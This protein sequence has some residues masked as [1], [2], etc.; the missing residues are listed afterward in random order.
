M[1]RWLLFL[2][3]SSILGLYLFLLSWSGFTFA[4]FLGSDEK[5]QVEKI[6]AVQAA[7][8]ETIEL[9]LKGSGFRRDTR[10]SL[11]M[12][13]SNRDAIVGS[14]PLKGIIHDFHRDGDILFVASDGGGL[15]VLDISDSL[16]PQ[17]IRKILTN[18]PVLD[19]EQD[20]SRLYLSCGNRGLVIFELRKNHQLKQIANIHGSS[21]FVKSKIHDGFIYVAAGHGGLLIYDLKEGFGSDPIVQIPQEKISRDLHFY[22]HYLYLQQFAGALIFDVANPAVPVLIGT[23]SRESNTKDIA[24]RGNLLFTTDS[25]GFVNRYLLNESGRPQLLDNRQFSST[26]LRTINVFEDNIY[27]ADGWNGLI[28]A[29]IYK[30]PQQLD[31]GYLEIDEFGSLAVKDDLLYVASVSD[32]LSIVK[33]N[34]IL[35]RQLVMNISS[36]GKAKDLLVDGDWLFVASQE[37]GLLAKNLRTGVELIPSVASRVVQSF[38]KSGHSL[39]LAKGEFGLGIMDISNPERSEEIVNFSEIKAFNLDVENNFLV[40][41]GGKELGLL[42]ISNRKKPQLLDRLQLNAADV[43]IS[44]GTVYAAAVRDGLQIY[45]ISPQGTL[46]YLAGVTPP[47]PMNQFATALNVDVV[48]SI[49]YVAN[50]ASG[51]QLIDVSNPLKPSILSS[52]D[53]PGEIVSVKVVNDRAFVVSPWNGIQVV[54]VSDPEQPR[55]VTNIPKQGGGGGIQ[56]DSGMLYLSNNW[57]GEFAIPLPQELTDIDYLSNQLIR[58]RIPSPKIKG[59]YSLQVNTPRESE[60][61]S[62]VVVI[63]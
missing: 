20:G 39:F 30:F 45:H 5:L 38:K 34:K 4:S 25:R 53:L 62:G 47:W 41:S 28:V 50:G 9:T 17:L 54:D 48:G 11:F 36:V 59:R 7:V 49:A 8:G 2:S 27:V 14:L 40:V 6:E 56:I 16:H 12:D 61:L 23:I 31:V 55:L 21:A 63:Q 52:I 26:G 13:V 58:V 43:A 37:Q 51:L 57:S 22:R 3:L 1:R 29:D 60:T 46:K 24:I 44:S 35:P 19:I 33:K 18:T 32:G 42:D 10:L 15:Q